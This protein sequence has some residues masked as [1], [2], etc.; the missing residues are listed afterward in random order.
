MSNST[1]MQLLL[2]CIYRKQICG[3]PWTGVYSSDRQH[4]HA[5]VFLM[6]SGLRLPGQSGCVF[7]AK[8]F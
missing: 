3:L 8:P 5:S 7:V 1:V 4:T 6:K 2:V